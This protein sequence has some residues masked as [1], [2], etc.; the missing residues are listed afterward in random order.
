MRSASHFPL[1]HSSRHTVLIRGALWH[2]L[3]HRA[4]GLP[5]RGQ[6]DDL[7]QGSFDQ[8]MA[9]RPDKLIVRLTS[10]CSLATHLAIQ[11]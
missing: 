6:I 4:E 10:T 7:D 1:S 11:I 2:K 5:Q 3:I 8:Y 9:D